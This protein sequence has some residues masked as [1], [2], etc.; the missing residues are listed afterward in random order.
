[1]VDCDTELFIGNIKSNQQSVIP[2][3]VRRELLA[4]S[5]AHQDVPGVGYK[6]QDCHFQIWYISPDR[7]DG[8]IF[9]CR[10]IVEHTHNESLQGI[11]SRVPGRDSQGKRHGKISQGDRQAVPHAFQKD[12]G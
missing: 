3:K 10:G 12:L 11:D 2:G 4:E 6:D 9:P 8:G 5:T 7:S 1:M